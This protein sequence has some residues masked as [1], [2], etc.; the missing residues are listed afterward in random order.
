MSAATS[1]TPADK[2][3]SHCTYLTYPF[4][5]EKMVRMRTAK[6]AGSFEL[7]VGGCFLGGLSLF[8]LFIMYINTKKRAD[9]LSSVGMMI[10]ES[11]YI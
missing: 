5:T 11:F 3:V 10:S 6:K 9:P 2:S 1:S 4:H 7:G 8:E